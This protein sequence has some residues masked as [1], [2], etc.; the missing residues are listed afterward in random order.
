M[1]G[2]VRVRGMS[3]HV[4]KRMLEHC[5]RIRTEAKRTALDAIAGPVLEIGVNQNVN[6]VAN[7]NSDENAKL[8]N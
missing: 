8:L 6:Q 2:R 7:T 4:S 5:S 3:P 1:V